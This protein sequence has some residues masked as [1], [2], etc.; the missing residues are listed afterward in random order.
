MKSFRLF[1][2]L[3]I[4]VFVLSAAKDYKPTISMVEAVNAGDKR[5]VAYYIKHGEDVNQKDKEDNQ[6]N[7]IPLFFFLIIYFYFFYDERKGH[8][9]DKG[10]CR[11]YELPQVILSGKPEDHYETHSNKQQHIVDKEPASLFIQDPCQY[12]EAYQG[13]VLQS[14]VKQGIRVGRP[15]KHA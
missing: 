14:A 9:Q 5:A 3:I 1:V 13:H 10:Y 4:G 2:T 11:Y 6:H 12:H 8:D 15:V 7:C